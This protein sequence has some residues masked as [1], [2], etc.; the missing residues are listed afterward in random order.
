MTTQDDITIVP[1]DVQMTFHCRACLTQF[2]AMAT[3][4]VLR[5]RAR[6]TLDQEARLIVAQHIRDCPGRDAGETKAAKPR[7]S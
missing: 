5:G 3:K 2:S 1:G 6:G 7:K 4:E